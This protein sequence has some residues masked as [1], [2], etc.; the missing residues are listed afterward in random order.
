MVTANKPLVTVLI[1]AYNY[2][3][4]IEDSVNSVLDQTLDPKKVEIILVDD[5]ST[6]DT[7][8]KI[9]NY[10]GKL[11]YIKKKNEGQA[12]AFNIGVHRASGKLIAFLDADDYWVP[13]KLKIA[14]E[15]FRE[16]AELDIFY[17]NLQIVDR[18][19][20]LI[21]PYYSDISGAEAPHKI[22]LVKY[23]QGHIQSFP[24][25]SG[26]MF[27]KSCLEKIMP[28]PIHYKICADTY[29]HYFAFFHSREMLFVPEILGYYR[30]HGDNLFDSGDISKK[31]QQLTS[32]YPLLINDLS[33]F[34]KASNRD[35][36][37]L[38][39]SIE[40]KIICWKQDLI[41]LNLLKSISAIKAY[42][43]MRC[44]YAPLM[45]LVVEPNRTARL[46]SFFEKRILKRSYQWALGTFHRLTSLIKSSVQ[47]RS[48]SSVKQLILGTAAG[49]KI[50]DIQPFIVSIKASGFKG[51]I[52]L[53]V[54]DPTNDTA[55]YLR[56]CSV[57]TLPFNPGR[58]PITNRRYFL[59]RQFLK[60][61]NAVDHV[62]LTDVRDVVFQ[63][64]PFESCKDDGIYFFEEDN[65]MTLQ[66]CSYNSN[67]I[68]QAYGQ[69]ILDALGYKPIICAGVTIGRLKEIR[70]YLGIICDQ[71]KRVPALRGI[72]QG[73]HNVMV[74]T[75]RFPHAVIQANEAGP[76]YTLHHVKSGN[77]RIDQD[78]HIISKYGIPA[79]VHQYDRHPL[80]VALVQRKYSTC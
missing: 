3:H 71:L 24:P 49:Y 5:G 25:T 80:L 73:V 40:R 22:D 18:H 14:V 79:V 13:D 20:N 15:H 48:S 70:D 11:I 50:S 62:M 44:I 66:S 78:G 21:R 55:Q 7:A 36:A 69:K 12:S 57:E 23:L 61:E 27:R 38:T 19:R 45:S 1:N 9:N 60:H 68:L 77:I 30:I 53:F 74:Y 6:D 16:Y 42:H 31:L 28:V 54:E 32:I 72:D 76:V 75:G 10:S 2:G 33:S 52:V 8:S 46:Y 35:T 29:L 37:L 26:M 34:S 43:L 51:R 59:Y 64:N 41:I 67:W 63:S 4:F 58:M 17:H 47:T 65:S 39:K 56:E